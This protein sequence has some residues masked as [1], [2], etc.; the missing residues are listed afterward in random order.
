MLSWF[1]KKRAGVAATGTVAAVRPVAPPKGESKSQQAEAARA[2][3]AA[4]LE[5]AQGD[6]AALWR[7]AQTASLLDIRCA[8]VAALQTEAA[9]KQA[10]RAL[11]SHDS[12][13]HRAAKLRLVAAV[14]QREARARAQTLIE[15]ATLLAGEALPAANQ[16][17]ALDRD[18]QALDASLLSPA[19]RT[20]FAEMRDRINASVHAHGEA[21]HRVHCWVVEARQALTALQAGVNA[22]GDDM[23]RRCEA[24]AL[25]RLS[26]PDVPA[27]AVLDQALAAALDT[28]R[29][30]AQRTEQQAATR[31]DDEAHQAQLEL[32]NTAR[33][34]PAATVESPPRPRL[35]NIAGPEALRQLDGLLDQSEAALASGRVGELQQRLHAVDAAFQGLNG[36]T[37]DDTRRA[38]RQALHAERARLQDW[39][40]WGGAQ[41][42]D[43]LVAEAVELAE[44]TLA[45]ADPEAI[46]APKL[47]LKT[48]AASIQA[49]RLRWNDIGRLGARAHQS[50]WQRFDTALQ[51][52][53]QPVAAQQALM[54]AARHDNLLARQALL[55]ALDALDAMP[56]PPVATLAAAQAATQAATQA[57][58]GAA[59]WKALLR[60]LGEFQL[61]WRQLGPVEHTVPASAKSALLQRLNTSVERIEAPLREAR[62]RAEAMRDQLIV[63]AEALAGELARNPALRDAAQ[64][65]R[66]LQAEWQ[67]QA[68][69]LP[70]ARA[71]EGDLWAR[72]KAA[73][74]A[75]FA[76][77]DA[78]FTALDAELSA[79]LA[80]REAL[81]ARLSSST[82][83]ASADEVRRTLVEV[84]RAWRQPME[85]PNAAAGSIEARYQSVRAAV[86]QWLA[87]GKQ[88]RWQAQCDTLLAKLRLCDEREAAAAE[89]GDLTRRWTAHDALPPAWQQALEQR[90]LQ[91]VAPG[92]L[93]ES[94][95]EDVLLKL[96]AALDVPAAPA[97]QAARR[98]LKL[99]T[100]KDTLEGR[101]P[102]E[103]NAES[104]RTEWLAAALRQA[105][106]GAARAERLRAVIAALRRSVPGQDAAEVAKR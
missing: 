77:R 62:R 38:R 73:T 31:A 40:Q 85:L 46:A 98:G 78:A 36:A 48:H 7:V 88:R 52:A 30:A 83:D 94:A 96:E 15:T 106:P 41:A 92:P 19:Q 8:A 103:A 5:A 61:A 65:V 14:A 95:M 69:A 28:L 71:V 84:D 27:T 47:H 56:A 68:R 2:E 59:A 54:K 99:R 35:A 81:L 90:W 21:Q 60:A 33:P 24:A 105:V 20:A 45:A 102:H 32:T 42:T 18:W 4:R 101:G 3:W 87:E 22:A 80:A 58:D 72:F 39:Q 82:A 93:A 12:R 25:L 57:D 17:V 1:F 9:L 86:V 13:V 70:L 63:R 97:L 6:D 50:L 100:L 44:A 10:E 34:E 29:L 104:Q 67:Q 64:R 75:V 11:R 26:R 16:L 53:Y 89:E 43:A 23:A 76:Q 79:N 37:L 91:P 55:D 51:T 49:L 66:E 74:D